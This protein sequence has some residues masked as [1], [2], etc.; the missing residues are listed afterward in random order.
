MNRFITSSLQVASRAQKTREFIL[1]DI[2]K[3]FIRNNS[4]NVIKNLVV[5]NHPTS[6]ISSYNLRLNVQ[7][8]NRR[9][10]AKT[11]KNVLEIVDEIK[12]LKIKF[13]HNTYNA[14]MAA[15]SMNKEFQ[16]AE[17]EFKKML[18]DGLEPNIDSYNIFLEAYAKTGR[19]KKLLELKEEIIEH[20]IQLTYNSYHYILKGL[21]NANEIEAA[22]DLFDQMK[23]K[24]MEP[25]LAI[26]A[27]LIQGCAQVLDSKATFDLL[28]EAEKLDLAVESQPKIYI[29]V[30]RLATQCDDEKLVNY[31]WNKV[32]QHFIRLDEGS[33]LE[34]LRVA[35]KKGDTQLATDV[36]RQLSTNGYTYKEHYFTPLMEAFIVKKDLKSAFNVLDIMRASGIAPSMRATLPIRQQLQGNVN[37]I[38][39]AYYIL[40]E[41]RRQKKTVDITAFN[42]VVAACADAKDIERTVATYREAK[43]LGVT[44]DV[45]T[46]N[47]VLE[48]CITTH[49]KSMGLVVIGEMKKADIK[50]NLE[51]Y[52][53][54]IRLACTGRDYD[55]AFE[56][57]E[58]MKGYDI[59]PPEKCY[60]T[61]ARKLAYENDPRFHMLLEEMETFGYPVTTKLRKL[62]KS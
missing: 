7:L 53:N 15:L 24:K 43:R 45:D 23:E 17:R 10:P 51:T 25:N 27:T 14:L 39:T 50:P 32:I 9:N 59:A 56:Y 36:I 57:L 35:S 37:D 5:H 61:L 34:V 49:M 29:N 31:C 12:Q 1:R 48:A 4:T 40:E 21:C 47:A 28:T 11:L 44:P 62:W 18:D 16:R 38:D 41:I 52:S 22:L 60:L 26:Y 30:L 3:Q 33:L 19:L 2:N 58:E 6:P 13:D 42:V 55:D 46:Y 54:M 20:N 8:R